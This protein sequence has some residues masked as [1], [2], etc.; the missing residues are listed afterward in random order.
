M[1]QLLLLLV[2]LLVTSGSLFAQ[3]STDLTKQ[4]QR[5]IADKNAVVG[6]GIS[7][8]QGEAVVLI[9]G[10]KQFPMQSVFKLPIGLAIL[11][12]VDQG[13]LEL[14]DPIKIT[15]AELRPNTWSPIREKFPKG[16]TMPLNE[17]LT[18]TIALS[19]NNGADILIAMLGSP[20]KVASFMQHSGIKNIAIKVNEHQMHKNWKLQ[21]KNWI[22][23]KASQHLLIRFHKNTSQLLSRRSHQFLWQVM[24]STKTGQHKLRGLLPQKAVVAHKTGSSGITPTGLTAADNDIGVVYLPNGHYFYISVFVT[25]SAET[26]AVNKAIIAKIAKTA[27]DYFQTKTR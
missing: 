18:Y 11:H 20:S 7:N 16:T 13:V 27:W 17:L 15:Q 9:N 4:I 6:V 1:K 5:I 19:D 10:K 25:H 23:P 8:E 2:A 14:D 12:Q 22:T 3:S 26:P 21:F 24:K